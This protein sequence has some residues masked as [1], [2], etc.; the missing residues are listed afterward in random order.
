M[1][2]STTYTVTVD[3]PVTPMEPEMM[4]LLLRWLQQFTLKPHQAEHL[5][6]IIRSRIA[7]EG[8]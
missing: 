3:M 6:V 4:A 5:M 2:R 8:Q 1:K 7:K